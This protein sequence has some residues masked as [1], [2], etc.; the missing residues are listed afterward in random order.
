M[1]DFSPL[2]IALSGLLAL[3]FGV[4][5]LGTALLHAERYPGAWGWFLGLF[6][7]ALLMHAC[8]WMMWRGGRRS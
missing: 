1:I 6:V 4:A 5:F 7:L 8:A 3:C 2:Y